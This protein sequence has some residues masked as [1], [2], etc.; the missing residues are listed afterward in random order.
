MGKLYHSG[1]MTFVEALEPL[2]VCTRNGRDNAN[3]KSAL[4]ISALS[5]EHPSLHS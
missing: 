2:G 5:T 3:D 4:V 1:M